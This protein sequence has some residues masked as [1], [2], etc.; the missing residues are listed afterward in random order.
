MHLIKAKQES[1]SGA[2]TF[3]K[4][5]PYII[6]FIASA[7][8]IRCH[9]FGLE[10]MNEFKI[11]QISGNVI[12]AIASTNAIVASIQVIEAIKILNRKNDP[13]IKLKELW[14]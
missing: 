14:V 11:K 8:N 9:I 13:S 4:D 5:D 2:I 6:K 10:M 12:P 7:A 3:E 1:K